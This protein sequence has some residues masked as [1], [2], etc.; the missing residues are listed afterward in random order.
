MAQ[1][2]KAGS[3]AWWPM[4]ELAGRR[5]DGTKITREVFVNMDKKDGEDRHQVFIPHDR[6]GKEIGWNGSPPVP[7]SGGAKD[8]LTIYS[9]RY[10][11]NYDTIQWEKYPKKNGIDNSHSS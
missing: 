6:D 9:P 10:V 5:E 1:L 3:Q 11:A 8:G 2:H 7:R 4:K